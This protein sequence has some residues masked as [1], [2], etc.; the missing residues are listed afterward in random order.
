MGMKANNSALTTELRPNRTAKGRTALADALFT[1]TQQKVLGL[2]FGQPDRSFFVTEV[3][4]LAKSGRGA[5]QREL[6]RLGTAG[7]VSVQMLGKQKHYQANR[8]SPLFNELCSIVRKTVGLEGPL[9][10]AVGQLPGSVRLALIYGSVARQTDTSTSDVDLLVVADELTL[11]DVY[12]ALSP[13]EEMLDRK[14][15]PT[16]YTSEEFEQRRVLANPF[17]M[18]VLSGPVIVLLGSIDGE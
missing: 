10:A 16:L 13:A 11:E 9:K 8:E 15:S 3:M 7:L 18:R 14:V 5:V 1:S 4:E 17:L 6:Q 2:L 12:A